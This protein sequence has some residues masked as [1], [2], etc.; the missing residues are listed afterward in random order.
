M[1]DKII[2]W[3]LQNRLIILAGSVL[4]A[5]VG[6]YQAEKMPIDIFPDLN[7]PQVV[8]M[9]E[10]H[11]MS[12][13]DVENLVT[14]P[15]EQMLNGVTGVD[16]VRSQSGMGLSVVTVQFDWGT[17]IYRNRQ[18]VQEKLQL[19]RELLP[20]EAV[21]QMMPV[22]SIM[23]QMQI[24]SFKSK[25]GKTPIE[26]VRALV[27]NEIRYRML[28]IPGVAKVVS[29]GGAP[30]QLQI[31][32]NP[33]RLREFNISIQEVEA[34]VK[35]RNQNRGGG[36]LEV[37]SSSP[38]ISVSGLIKNET[39]L[40]DAVI[41]YR[42]G[43]SI[44]LKDVALVEFGPAAVQ[45]G[46]A[47]VNGE[48]AVLMTIIKQ[49]ETDTLKLSQAIEKSFSETGASMPD[50]EINTRI[51][52][53]ADFITRAIDNV[54]EAVRDGGIMVVVILVLFLMNLRISFITLTAIPLSIGISALVFAALDLGINT[55]TLGGLAV[56]IGALVDDAIV[57]VEN[58]FRRLKKNQLLD[59][60]QRA[61]VLEVVFKAS[62]EVRKPILI[63]TLLV[64]V[65]YLPLFFLTGMEGILFTPI[66]LAYIISIAASL[67]VALTVTP[68]LCYYLLPSTLIKKKEH[69]D[70]IIVAV[71]KKMA[72]KVI[73][74]SIKAR[75]IIVVL[76]IGV[77]F[78]TAYL[79]TLQ[80][81][82]FLP[83]FDEGSVQ[84]NMILPPETG[85]KKTDQLGQKMEEELLKIEGVEFVGRRSGRAYGDEHAEGVNKS[86]ALLTF[87][88]N[89]SRSRKEIIEDIRSRLSRRFPGIVMTTEQ[90][91][92]HLISH[93]LSGVYAQVAIKVEGKDLKVLK[94]T[95][96]KIE[97]AVT[98][99]P[100]V[101]DPNV[102]QQVLTP[103]IKVIPRSEDM[104]N[105]GVTVEEIADV[106]ELSL[107]GS[108]VSKMIDGPY[109]YPIIVRL[110]HKFRESINDIL[111]LY[112]RNGE[113][114]LLRL[115]DV[116]DVKMLKSYNIIRHDNS[117][118]RMVF[119]HNISGSS[120]G[121]VVEKVNQELDVIR[122]DLPQ[123]YS[124][125]LKGQYEAQQ[126]AQNR[127]MYLS[128][129]SLFLMFIIL[130]SHF[131]SISLSLQIMASIPMAF[132][133]AALYIFLDNQVISIATLVGLISLGGIA[134]RNAILLIDHYI[135]LIIYEGHDFS[136]ATLIEA[137]QERLVPVL[138]TALTSGIALV[139]IAMSAG[140][141]G[142]EILYPVATV[143]IGGLISSTILDFVLTPAVFWAVGRKT[144]EK[145]KQGEKR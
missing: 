62:S 6:L 80:G 101:T 50:I 139:P 106:V 82:Q 52:R 145:L 129:V 60:A 76:S 133:G 29:V 64:I 75:W 38:V 77:F 58:V 26:T 83:E 47:G 81:T 122:K 16:S 72:A 125:K 31:Y 112:V 66:G 25:S 89:I 33:D 27:D 94:N 18:M 96:E 45:I 117:S 34:A 51:F 102:E 48:R 116:A 43:R 128:V 103:Q 53:Q 40:N 42:E 144:I 24:I 7:K 61:P 111:N 126:K 41:A 37:G 92:A 100:G 2:L 88:E 3:A 32:C 36:F 143:I 141:P 91:L 79:I 115:A 22:S 71:M 57:D 5:A 138:M 23:G 132:I 67:F 49:P 19:V 130:Y 136:V 44:T 120:L 73:S 56:A 59:P 21:P 114:E 20:D 8:I 70:T 85:L 105:Y 68:V 10:A 98:G 140:E 15:V 65:V 127:L 86:E 78:G 13:E 35:K 69:K 123:G 87:N 119:S 74:V 54:L 99:I 9:T 4:I 39:D 109:T 84:V 1:L 137:G 97:A 55:M 118:R 142:K 121:E 108:E 135:H 11:S 134:S 63:G 124:I 12:S 30:K 17:D 28:A 131:K 113:G 14:R 93:M 90:P 107:E 110:E 104:I 46:N 95:V